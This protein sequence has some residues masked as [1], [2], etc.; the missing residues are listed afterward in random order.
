LFDWIGKLWTAPPPP[1]AK[2][3]VRIDSEF[4]LVSDPA[5][6]VRGATKAGLERVVIE[7]NDSGPWGADVWWLLFADHHEPACAFPMGA[8]GERSAVDYLMTLPGFDHAAMLRAMS[9]TANATFPVWKRD[10]TSMAA[11]G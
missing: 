8:S 10:W 9:S 3:V 5:G 4:I 1:E 2:W 7:T 11:S 6:E